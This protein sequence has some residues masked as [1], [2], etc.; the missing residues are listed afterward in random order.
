[1]NWPDSWEVCRH[2]SSFMIDPADF[3]TALIIDDEA[4]IRRLLRLA[5]ESKGYE[6]HES[7]AGLRGIQDAAF[8]RPDVVVL[9]LGLP[10]IDGI[11]VLRR[12]REWS[13]VP[14]IVLTVRD[15]E[16]IKVAALDSGADDYVTKPFGTAELI[17]RL[18]AI[19]RRKRNGGEPA[20]TVGPLHINFVSQ[21]ATLSGQS[22]KLTPI[23]YAL[24]KA[25]ATRAGR[26]VT[27]N[28]LIHE[29]WPGQMADA[30]PALRVHM[31]HLRKKVQCGD[32]AG[33][34]EIINEP[35]I[36]YRL[37]AS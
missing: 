30:S 33:Q 14:I 15:Q 2:Q 20:C 22:L 8:H 16:S 4:P 31:N 28:Q 21:E 27:Q 11:E 37:M 32:P 3:M 13:D 7:A 9:D 24:L 6:V 10:D 34:I 35:G 5:L 12:L 1:M 26:I 36:G 17:A 25:L 19:Q 23:E 18:A 29:V